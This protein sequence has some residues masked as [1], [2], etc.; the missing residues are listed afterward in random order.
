MGQPGGIGPTPGG[1]PLGPGGAPA[2]DAFIGMSIPEAAKKRLAAVRKKLA[3]Q[4]IMTALEAGGLPSSKY[5]TVYAIL[6]R[7]QK[8][9]GDLIN[10]KGD[11]ALAEWYPNFVRGKGKPPK[12]SD[13]SEKEESNK[14]EKTEKATA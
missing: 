9:V 7:R 1:S 10:M 5:T 6:S 14:A 4:E 2:H 12:S 8:Q 13:D 11:W 3:T